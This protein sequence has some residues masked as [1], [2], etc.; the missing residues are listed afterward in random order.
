VFIEYTLQ[1]AEN[2]NGFFTNRYT[3]DV[4]SFHCKNI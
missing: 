1:C 4:M 2:Y 3:T